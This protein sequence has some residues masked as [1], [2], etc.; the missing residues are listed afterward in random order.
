M[1]FG[2]DPAARAEMEFDARLG[3]LAR[4]KLA[5]QLDCGDG[6]DV[7]GLSAIAL[8]SEGVSNDG[9]S[10]ARAK[11]E[12]GI[13]ALGN[14]GFLYRPLFETRISGSCYDV[15]HARNL[16]RQPANHLG[17]IIFEAKRLLMIGGKILFIDRNDKAAAQIRETFG[18]VD[19]RK[20]GVLRKWFVI[21]ATRGA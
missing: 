14:V 12:A 13:M 7:M 1:F 21:E 3:V 19:V 17:P 9:A 5:L 11:M 4:E 18:N 15:I 2:E 10:I 6:G 20:F 8:G 16:S